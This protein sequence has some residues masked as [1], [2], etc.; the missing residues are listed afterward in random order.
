VSNRRC[1]SCGLIN[2][3]DAQACRKCGN[4]LSQSQTE[5][6]VKNTASYQDT[7]EGLSPQA[8]IQWVKWLLIIAGVVITITDW[9][10][11]IYRDVY[12]GK[13]SFGGPLVLMA[14]ILLFFIPT[15]ELVRKGDLRTRT[16][17]I[18]AVGLTVGAILGFL[19][20]SLMKN[21]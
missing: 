13:S 7:I 14:G 17:I 10:F 16:K 5:Q 3:N 12:H 18:M 21:Y 9:L 1:S 19:N 4:R 2:F 11:L 15:E 20:Q 8:R 6:E